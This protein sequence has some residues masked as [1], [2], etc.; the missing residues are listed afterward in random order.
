AE[1]LRACPRPLAG[2]CL[3]IETFGSPLSPLQ[4]RE[5][6]IEFVRQLGLPTIVVTPSHVGAI[7]RSLQCVRA[8]AHWELEPAAIVLLGPRD[9]YAEERIASLLGPGTAVVSIERPGSYDRAELADS[10]AGQ[11][12]LLRAIRRQV[13]RGA[14]PGGSVPIAAGGAARADEGRREGLQGRSV[15]NIVARDARAVWHPYTPLQ[16]PDPPLVVVDAEEEFITLS[17]GRRLI[18]AISS[19]WTILYG[20]RQPVLVEALAAAVRQIDHVLFAGLTH[21][22]AVEL[23]ELMLAS[24]PWAGG[25]VFFSDNGSTAVEV[26]LK[27]ARQYWVLKGQGQRSV[28]VSFEGAYH[29]D[30]AGAMS[31]GRDKRF[32]TPFEPMLFDVEQVPVCPERLEAALAT[33]GDRA[34]AVIIEP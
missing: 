25:R 10:A 16:D 4:G 33:L 19:W 24:M 2:R 21:E 32:F 6:Q 29:G 28:F 3:L 26:A 27:M 23:A 34:A 30:T 17:D 13:E 22:P 11:L 1:L 18:D 15:E 8:M 9:E 31:V 5:L 20:H 7:G 12:P 14:G